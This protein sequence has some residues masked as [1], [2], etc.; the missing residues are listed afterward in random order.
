MP[1]KDCLT[2]SLPG[3]PRQHPCVIDRAA[4][5]AEVASGSV[6][7]DTELLVAGRWI[8]LRDCCHVPWL[9]EMRARRLLQ[10]RNATRRVSR[11][12]TDRILLYGADH[13]D[14][15]PV[16]VAKFLK[17]HLCLC[18]GDDRGAVFWLNPAA[19]KPSLVRAPAQNNL[20]VA[21]ARLGEPVAALDEFEA[22]LAGDAGLLVAH[23]NLR[24][25]AG[26]MLYERARNLPGRPHGASCT[27]APTAIYAAYRRRR[28]KVA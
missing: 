4:F 26:R 7:P 17:A 25:L 6:P 5:I 12:L 28:S 27:A 20:G 2:V 24:A 22:A 9:D 8:A 10:R 1:T 23:V 18:D 14:R 11:L 15:E 19:R 13:D 16:G 3:C 21:W